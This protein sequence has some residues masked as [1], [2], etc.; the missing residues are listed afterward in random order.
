MKLR[1]SYLYLIVILHCEKTRYW[2]VTAWEIPLVMFGVLRARPTLW[3]LTSHSFSYSHGTAA[4]PFDRLPRSLPHTTD[5]SATF[6]PITSGAASVWHTILPSYWRRKHRTAVFA[7]YE[8]EAVKHGE[9]S[10]NVAWDARPARWLHHPDSAWLLFGVSAAA[11]LIDPDPDSISEVL[12][13][14]DDSNTNTYRVTGL[15]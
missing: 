8:N 1:N 12:V 10:W 14:S 3:L 7:R 5:Y 2:S 11:P 9:G 6:P 4:P 15:D 13:A